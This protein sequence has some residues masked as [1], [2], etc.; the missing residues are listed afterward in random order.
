[1]TDFKKGDRVRVTY[2]GEY[3]RY[4]GVSGHWVR[5]GGLSWDVPASATIEK[6]VPALP[7][8]PGSV[9]RHKSN[10]IDS[11]YV[12]NNDGKWVSLRYGTH[13]TADSF[14]ANWTTIYEVI[15]D[16]GKVEA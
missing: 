11:K 9:V 3:D 5:T 8:T 1:M 12:L 15:F 6:L 13:G 10:I 4:V 16:A 14:G 7:T 2:E